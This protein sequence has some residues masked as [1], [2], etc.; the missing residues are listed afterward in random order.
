VDTDYIPYLEPWHGVGV[1]AEAFGCPFEWRKDDSPWCHPIVKDIAGLH[2]LEKPVLSKAKMLNFVC[3]TVEFFD[4]QT[5][6][7]IPIALTDTQS[8]LDNATLICDTTFFFM[9]AYEHPDEI[10]RLLQWVTDLM[11][12]ASRQQRKLARNQAKPG[13]VMW[14]P[15][16]GRGLSI[17][18]D[19]LV[20]IGSDF[21]E[22]F[23]K[24]YNMQLADA[25]G[26]LAV[27]S[28][29]EWKQHFVPLSETPGVFMCDLAL[30]PVGDP[31]PHKLEDVVKGF[32]GRN[33]LVQIRTEPDH[34]DPDCMFAWIDQLRGPGFPMII[35]IP[36]NGD[37]KIANRNYS[38][39]RK[40]LDALLKRD[41]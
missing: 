5:Q 34:P 8:P 13:H 12:D 17:S 25:F 36:L 21:Y 6:G 18:E 29:G 31:N 40:K 16:D 26:G 10:K 35:Q 4:R 11:I 3:D 27:H 33:T 37:P 39:L 32:V 23:A 24:P 9:S 2:R 38:V 14:S 30:R 15:T 7:Q 28:C 41:W 20:M 1:Y 22:E 19:D